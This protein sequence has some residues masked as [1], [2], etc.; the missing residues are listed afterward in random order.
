MLR[1]KAP[2]WCRTQIAGKYTCLAVLSES[3]GR[4]CQPCA[5]KQREIAARPI[6]SVAV[7]SDEDRWSWWPE[8]VARGP[9]WA[10]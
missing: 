6:R 9:I 5:D 7:K 2:F 3:D 4:L 10:V 8:R 1:Q